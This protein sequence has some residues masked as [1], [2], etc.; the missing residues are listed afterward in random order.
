MPAD[1]ADDLLQEFVVSK[2]LEQ[3][4][5]ARAK[6]DRGKFRTFLLTSLRNFVYDDARAARA[7]KRS[8]V[9]GAS[10]VDESFDPPDTRVKGPSEAF[11]EAWAR[12][13]PSGDDLNASTMPC[14]QPV[15]L[16]EGF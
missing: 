3:G 11:D 16:V 12:G 10:G 9:S 1:T 6:A 13:D 5:V 7:K 8:A 14:R 2:V 4:L 15:E